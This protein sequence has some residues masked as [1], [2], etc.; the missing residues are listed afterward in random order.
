[1]NEIKKKIE[2][3]ETSYSFK[4]IPAVYLEGRKSR[5]I[6]WFTGTIIMG[7]CILFLPWT[8]NIR[9]RGYVTINAE[10]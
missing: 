9:A 3:L 10:N 4:S 1:M 5:V 2:A 7:I 8:Q 6:K